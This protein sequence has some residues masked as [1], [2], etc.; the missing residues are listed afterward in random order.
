[1]FGVTLENAW[2]FGWRVGGGH[3]LCAGQPICWPIHAVAPKLTID[4]YQPLNLWL[5]HIRQIIDRIV[6]HRPQFA[7]AQIETLLLGQ[8]ERPGADATED[9]DRLLNGQFG[10]DDVPF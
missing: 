3:P 6:A 9:A 8:A 1:L 2:H 7:V 4:N 5:F 10:E